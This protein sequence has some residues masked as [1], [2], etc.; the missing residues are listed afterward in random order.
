[1]NLYNGRPVSMQDTVL[2]TGMDVVSMHRKVNHLQIL[3]N[4]PVAMFPAR[5]KTVNKNMFKAPF[6]K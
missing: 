6:I 1:M 5:I 4:F 3:E 2:S